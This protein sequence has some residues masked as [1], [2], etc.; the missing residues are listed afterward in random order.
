MFPGQHFESF[1]AFKS[2]LGK[3]HDKI[4]GKLVT[5]ISGII[6]KAANVKIK[7]DFRYKGELVYTRYLPMYARGQVFFKGGG[8]GGGGL[9]TQRK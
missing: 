2:V 8:G 6:V 7:K 5:G 3:Q 9:Q 4:N 1:E